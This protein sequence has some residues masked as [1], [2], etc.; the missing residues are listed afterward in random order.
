MGVPTSGIYQA[1][2]LKRKKEQDDKEFQSFIDAIDR[3]SMSQQTSDEAGSLKALMDANAVNQQVEAG[4]QEIPQSTGIKRGND[5]PLADSLAKDAVKGL[6]LSNPEN[7]S[8]FDEWLK[9]APKAEEAPVTP[10]VTQKG[11]DIST[12]D[13]QAIMDEWIK[14]STPATSTSKV[15]ATPAAT[16]AKASESK[17][18]P[19]DM[20]KAEQLFKTTHGSAFDPKSSM[21]KR[22]MEEITG[23]LSKAGSD[24]LTPNQFALKIYRS[25]K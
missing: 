3:R 16:T 8:R 22:K 10:A 15:A 23:L 4:R 9:N 25:H 2:V 13:K 18:E 17:A 20:S 11:L 1:D 24:K 14:N 6:D 7:L 21:D 5:E 12:P 19:V